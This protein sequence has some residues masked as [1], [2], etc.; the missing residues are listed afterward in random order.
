MKHVLIIGSTSYI[1]NA[2]QKYIGE[3]AAVKKISVRNDEWRRMDFSEF[4]TILFCA[5]IV[6]KKKGLY[7]EEEYEEINCELPVALAK[8]AK[9][10]GVSQFV[11]LSSMA[12]YGLEGNI[13][14]TVLIDK[15][16]E[17]DPKSYYGK[18]KYKAEFFL[19]KEQTDF[20]IVTVVRPPMVYGE[21]CP[22]N[23]QRLK[24][25]VL[26]YKVF[27]NIK[28]QRS[29][30][31]ISHLCEKLSELI[32]ERKSGIFHPQDP[33]YI[34]TLELAKQISRESGSVL[35]ISKALSLLIYLSSPFVQ[36]VHKVW[37]GLVY[38]KDID[39]L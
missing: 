22:G 7:T 9:E 13:G 32:Q 37:G 30:I 31:S 27:P 5:A 23:Y 21:N 16:I 19:L 26:K 12:V 8:K 17:P 10:E 2:F 38:D 34:C 14:S 4:D 29:M 24:R 25:I 33:E 36:I 39:Q 20:F 28:N 6:H 18:S 1:G 11:F 35:H 15:G 3:S